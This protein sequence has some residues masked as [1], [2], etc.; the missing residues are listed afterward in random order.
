MENF[1]MVFVFVKMALKINFVFYRYTCFV[2]IIKIICYIKVCLGVSQAVV[3][4]R[5]L[6]VEK[7]ER[8]IIEP[9]GYIYQTLLVLTLRGEILFLVE[10][11]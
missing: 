11:I 2:V 5:P 9:S 4:G 7:V 1:I 6:F 8:H 10:I 3:N